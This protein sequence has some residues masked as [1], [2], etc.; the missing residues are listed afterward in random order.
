MGSLEGRSVVVT[1]AARGLGAAIAA[2]CVEQGAE[3]VLADL[4]RDDVEETASKLGSSA[5]AFELDVTD[6]AAWDRFADVLHDRFGRPD[7]LVNNAGIIIP[8]SV[9][10]TTVDRFRQTLDVN[11]VGMFS[12][13]QTYV[14][15]H[16][17]TACERPGSII[18]MASARG[19]VAAKEA[20]SY[21]TS[22]FAVRGLTKAAAI[23][24]GPL[25][26]RVN[27]I[28]PGAIE[29]DMSSHNP[30][31]KTVD[32]GAYVREMPLGRMG[33][34]VEIAEAACWLASDASA[35]VTGIDLV[36]DGGLTTNG[37][38]LKPL[39]PRPS[40]A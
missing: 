39:R 20:I 5:S 32:W 37:I 12:G 29:T 31:F 15:L 4:R 36:V 30:D 2:G 24:L 18:N 22:K 16:H 8:E 1:G 6:P 25:G 38:S 3:V 40:S 19:L 7:V 33:R 9:E 14:A 21:V 23:E 27:A 26:I 35:F 13:I 28:C 34:P 17:K 10:N 11:V